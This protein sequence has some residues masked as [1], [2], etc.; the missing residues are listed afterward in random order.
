MATLVN[1]DQRFIICSLKSRIPRLPPQSGYE[2]TAPPNVWHR[3]RGSPGN[4]P[5]RPIKMWECPWETTYLASYAHVRTYKPPHTT[6]PDCSLFVKT[7]GNYYTG[8]LFPK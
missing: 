2:T 8:I 7:Y 3:K 5:T 1:K 6:Q 4:A